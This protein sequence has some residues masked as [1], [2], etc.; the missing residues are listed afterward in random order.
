MSEQAFAGLKVFDASQGVAGPHATM[1]MALHGAD[2]VKVEP[3]DGDWGRVLGRRVDQ[4][5]I[6]FRAFNAAKRSVAIDLKSPSGI[7]VARRMAA[8]ADIVV[9][10]YRP[11]VMAKL[12]LDHDSVRANNAHVIY[13]SISGYGQQG[14][15]ARAPATDALIQAYSGMMRMNHTSD[16]T[17]HRSGMIV[18]DGLTGLYA[19]QAIAAALI[20]RLRFSQGA[21]LDISLAQSAAAFQAAKIMEWVDTGGRTMPLYVPSGMYRT[22]DGYVVINGMRATHFAAVCAALDCPDLATDP[23]WPTP[24]ARLDYLGEINERLHTAF[25]AIDTAT[26]LERLAANGVMAERVRDYGEW[27]AEPHVRESAGAPPPPSP[28][29]GAAPGA[30][31]PGRERAPTPTPPPLIGE[32]TVEILAEMGY[33]PDWVDREIAA[34]AF[35]RSERAA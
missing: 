26:V 9:E 29:C 12:G 14:P 33:A 2:V 22:S 1:L 6:H 3:I 13:A 23:R 20:R 18:V 5:T 16:G 34:G 30:G 11:G 35:R 27:L 7:D 21:Y 32:H 4:E 17:P 31:V 15:N 8:E 10:S 19:F 24:N 25:A 28:P